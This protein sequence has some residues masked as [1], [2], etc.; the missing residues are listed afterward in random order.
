MEHREI[1][2]LSFGHYSNFVATHYFNAQESL[3]ASTDADVSF[4]FEGETG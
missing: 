1:L 3:F 4:C 2:T